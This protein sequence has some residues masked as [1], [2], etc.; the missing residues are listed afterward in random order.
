[1]DIYVKIDA[2]F[3][4]QREVFMKIQNRMPKTDNRIHLN[5]VENEWFPMNKPKSMGVATLLSIPLMSLNALIT[6][7]VINFDDITE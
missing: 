5:L 1:M 4:N 6:I 7:S 2:D 3:V